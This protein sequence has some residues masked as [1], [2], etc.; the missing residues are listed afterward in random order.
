MKSQRDN[1]VLALSERRND[2]GDSI[3]API[4]VSSELLFL[5]K[6][7]EILVGGA[8]DTDIYLNIFF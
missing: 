2:G 8:D 3:D 5:N 1:V 4:E 7:F 6:L